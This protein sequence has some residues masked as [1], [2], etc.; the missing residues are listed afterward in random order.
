M[1]FN[2]NGRTENVVTEGQKFGNGRTFI[3]NLIWIELLESLRV[4]QTNFKLA[5]KFKT[6]IN[7]IYTKIIYVLQLKNTLSI[8]KTCKIHKFS[9]KLLVFKFN[10]YLCCSPHL[11][12]A[13][14]STV[15]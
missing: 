15:F 3:Y 7:N 1:F 12:V 6:Y 14:Q 11:C 5:L 9:I 13:R 8:L 4:K 2:G 10:Y